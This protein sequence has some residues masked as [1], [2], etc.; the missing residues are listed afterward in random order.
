MD[1]ST[2]IEELKTRVKDYC[3]VRDWD[4]FHHAKELSIN[5]LAESSELLQLFRF[6][7]NEEVDV[8][9]QDEVFRQKVGEEIADVAYALLRL[10]QK[11]NF[12][13]STEFENKMLKNEHKYPID[14]FKSSPKKYN[15]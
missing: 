13:L 6:K 3:E 11:Y 7:S 4:Q 5:I 1:K 2:S 10:V 9:L 14:K 8:L 15:E 12:D